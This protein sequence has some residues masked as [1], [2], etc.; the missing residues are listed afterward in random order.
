MT[1]AE[2]EN[3]RMKLLGRKFFGGRKDNASGKSYSLLGN[4]TPI[5]DSLEEPECG[6]ALCQPASLKDQLV[7][8]MMADMVR[9]NG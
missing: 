1:K 4:R 3:D 7:I 2:Q 5:A 8:S 6:C 9:N